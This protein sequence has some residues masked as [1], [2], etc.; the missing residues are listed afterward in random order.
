VGEDAVG[1]NDRLDLGGKPEQRRAGALSSEKRK[2]IIQKLYNLGEE[3]AGPNPAELVELIELTAIEFHKGV[4][5]VHASL[6]DFVPLQVRAAFDVE[7]EKCRRGL[8][9]LIRKAKVANKLVKPPDELAPAEAIPFACALVRLSRLPIDDDAVQQVSNAIQLLA[10]LN[11]V[12]VDEEKP[13]TRP[14]YNLRREVVRASYYYRAHHGLSLTLD[15]QYLDR[16][17]VKPGTRSSEGELEPVTPTATLACEVA[18]AFDLRPDTAEV[19][20]HLQ[21]YKAELKEEG[22]KPRR[23]DFMIDLD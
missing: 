21:N 2:A 11:V 6:S 15:F 8:R 16:L 23:S 3:V 10:S 13:G 22:R 1:T 14:I 9:D 17:G 5:P 7:E 20:T 18:K 19:Q 4:A 12:L